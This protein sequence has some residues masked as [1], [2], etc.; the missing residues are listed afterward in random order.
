MYQASVDSITDC[1]ILLCSQSYHDA[2]RFCLIVI[3]VSAGNTPFID[4]VSRVLG[5]IR[6]RPLITHQVRATCKVT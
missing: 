6:T 4:D 2:F 5:N 3:Y 1:H